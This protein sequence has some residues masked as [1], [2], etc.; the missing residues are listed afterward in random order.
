MSATRWRIAAM[1]IAVACAACRRGNAQESLR[2]TIRRKTVELTVGDTT[3]LIAVVTL[4]G[5]EAPTTV[6]WASDNGRIASVDRNGFVTARGTGVTGITAS[7]GTAIASTRVSVFGAPLAGDQHPAAARVAPVTS[8]PATAP[9]AQR[10][11]PAAPAARIEATRASRLQPAPSSGK[12]AA[13]SPH[14]SHINLFYTDFYS[15]YASPSDQR[16]TLT[17]LGARLDGVMS[18]PRDMWKA[19]D[20]TILHFPY[21]LQYTVQIPGQKGSSDNIASGY[22]TDMQQWYASHRQYDIEN[23]FLHRG[24]HDAAH[25]VQMKIWDSM[26]FAINPSDAGQ[27]AYQV[28]RLQRV[29]QNE[30][31]VFLDEFGGGMSGASKPSDEFATPATYMTSETELIA[32][33]HEAIKPRFLLINIGEYWTPAD[34][35]IVV[36]G[37]GAHLERTNFP[38]TDRLPARWTQIDNLL[39]M[40]VYTEF[41]TLWTYTDWIRSRS[42][43][44]KSFAGGMYSSQLER[45]QLMQLASYYMAVPADPSRYSL[46]MQNM[47]DVRPDTAWMAAVEADVGHPREARHSIA[48]GVDAAGQKYRIYARDFD[49]AYV[50]IRPQAD[51]RPQLYADSTGIVVPLPTP[52]R[53]LH[54]DGSLGAAVNSV[55]LRNVEAAILFK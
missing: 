55:T 38:F 53:P 12:R 35:A 15:R 7:I 19:V 25:R 17:F 36:A 6:T 1:V 37:G 22:F 3:T 20:P 14:F 10:A 23:A 34:S 39:A 40:N 9:V 49:H 13:R 27:R 21:A 47:W 52:M 31:G 30:D 50:V 2:I 4:T 16:A 43:K 26:R 54:R 42:S 41:V 33:V 45:G 11:I 24:G 44:F 5:E 29:A 32:K 48:S 46:D 18:G 8:P 28:D 51:W